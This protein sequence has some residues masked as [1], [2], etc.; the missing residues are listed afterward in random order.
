M[1]KVA[2]PLFL[3]L[4]L[5]LDGVSSQ[6][7]QI[8]RTPSLPSPQRRRNLLDERVA[9]AQL[10]AKQ[11]EFA[12]HSM[13]DGVVDVGVRRDQQRLRGGESRLDDR[14]ERRGAELHRRN[15]IDDDEVLLADG[16]LDC[17]NSQLLD[18]SEIDDVPAD[19]RPL[20]AVHMA[21][22]ALFTGGDVDDGETD[23]VPADADLARQHAS[24]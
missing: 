9:V 14:H 11:L 6:A 3:V 15:L 19:S 2:C 22:N 4:V 16:A 12:A 24:G 10:D 8:L 21:E 13:S 17:G 1:R 18:R 20:S 5:V 23:A 7:P